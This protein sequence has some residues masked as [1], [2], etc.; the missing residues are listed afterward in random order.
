VTIEDYAEEIQGDLRYIQG[1]VRDWNSMAPL[2][3]IRL[4]QGS[5]KYVKEAQFV[6]ASAL[7]FVGILRK[8]VHMCWLFLLIREW[9]DGQLDVLV[10][11][12]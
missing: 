9:F 4:S 1:T 8:T 10:G 6:L 2:K 5:T 7:E 12:C 11:H 3:V